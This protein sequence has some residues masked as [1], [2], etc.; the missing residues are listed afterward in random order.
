MPWGEKRSSGLYRAGWRDAAG[1]IQH[2]E[3]IYLT[4]HAAEAAAW[5]AAGE[6]RKPRVTSDLTWSQWKDLWLPSRWS[7]V[8]AS[9]RDGDEGRIRKWVEPQW[10]AVLLSDITTVKVRAW[11]RRLRSDGVS[12]SSIEKI[13]RLLSA[14]LRDAVEDEVLTANPC[15]GIKLAPPEPGHERWLEPEEVDRAV[16]FMERP[17]STAVQ[18]LAETGLRYGELAGL[19][20]Q[21]V[22]LRHGRAHVVE[23]WSRAGGWIEPYPKGRKLRTIPLSDKAQEILTSL[24]RNPGT[25]GQQHHG[26]V[27]CRSTL[28][29]TGPRGVPLDSHNMRDRHWVPALELAGIDHA[30]QHDL[31]H[32]HASWLAQAGVA[33]TDIAEMLGHSD[34]YVTARYKHMA[35]RHLDRVREALNGVRTVAPVPQDQAVL[36]VVENED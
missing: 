9:T 27:A 28:V 16:G 5:V 35:N 33:L 25:C 13:Y 26:G 19:H 30:R 23:A 8:A 31:R 7:E 22:D 14:S 15:S 12:P 10:G 11:V 32:S 34:A 1:K 17:Y 3:A 29:L 2:S 21:R 4:K 20:W 24:A 18:L 6:A 36:G